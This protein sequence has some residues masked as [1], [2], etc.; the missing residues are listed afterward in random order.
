MIFK[1]NSLKSS[2]IYI[3]KLE[4][5][6]FVNDFLMNFNFKS[7]FEQIIDLLEKSL[8]VVPLSKEIKIIGIFVY[9]CSIKN[10]LLRNLC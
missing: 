3:E 10:N 6:S 7:D 5:I 8:L 1:L 4:K 2:L 9:F